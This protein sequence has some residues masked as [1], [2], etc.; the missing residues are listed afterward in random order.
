M[1]IGYGS[2]PLQCGQNLDGDFVSDFIRTGFRRWKRMKVI[3]IQAHKQLLSPGRSSVTGKN[4]VEIRPGIVI[5]FQTVWMSWSKSRE[6][7]AL[8]NSVLLLAVQV[9]V[10][11]YLS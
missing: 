7:M 1:S 4:H 6:T 5:C 8:R 10:A 9:T 3:F 11:I 2:G